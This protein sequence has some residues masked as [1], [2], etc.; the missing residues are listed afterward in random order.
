MNRT[1]VNTRRKP[2][3]TQARWERPAR[4]R[5]LPTISLEALEARTLLTVLDLTALNSSG[6]IN[7]AIFNQYTA[8]QDGT[9][10]PLSPFV[11]LLSSA[12]IVQ[13]YNT[14]A[15]PVQFNE[16]STASVTHGIQL[17]SVPS[18]IAP[19]GIRYYEFVL[20]IAQSDS[21]PLLSLDELRLYVTNP[22]TVQPASLSS[23]DS[24]TQTL[25]DASGK[26]YAPVYDLDAGG[27]S[28]V[29]LNADLSDKV[30]DG[31]G[32]GTPGDM[33][34][35]VPATDLGNDPSQYVYLY[36]K[37]GVNYRN[38]GSF[39]QWN[40]GTRP[41]EKT[42]SVSGQVYVDTNGD[43]LQQTGEPPLAGATV[44]LDA[45]NNGSFDT[46]ELTTVTGSDG[47]FSFSG[48][49]AGT[50]HVRAITPA[51]YV[52]TGSAS[53]DVTLTAGQQAT[54]TSFGFFAF[55]SLS[56]SRYRDLTGDGLSAD[57]PILNSQNPL[58]QPITVSLYKGAALAATTTIDAQGNYSF[59]NLGPGTYTVVEAVPS[60]WFQTQGPGAYTP[61]SGQQ[62]TGNN[63]DDFL[64][65]QIS[66]SGT[67]QVL[68]LH[69]TATPSSSLTVTQ[70]SSSGFMLSLDNKYTGT[71]TAPNVVNLQVNPA[72]GAS[73]DTTGVNA[74]PVVIGD[75]QGDNAYHTGRGGTT[76]YLNSGSSD[77]ISMAGG[78]NTLNLS[79]NTFGVT[80]DA[81]LTNGTPQPLDSTGLHMLSVS[82]QFQTVVGSSFNDK[83]TAA[84][85]MFDPT[86]GTVGAGTTII[87]G[88]G[89][90]TI[91]GSLGTKA[92]ILGSGSSY[93]QALS[94]TAL[95]TLAQAVQFGASA[96]VLS[97][98]G[99][100]VSAGGGFATI[101]AGILTN[102]NLSGNSNQFNQT[103]SSSTASLINQAVAQFG[104]TPAVLGGF[105]NT[106]TTLGRF[107]TVDASL[108][109]KVDLS[110]GSNTFNQV[111]DPGAVSVLQSA[112]SQFGGTAASVGG[113]GSA[114]G[115]LGSFRNTVITTGNSQVSASLLTNVTTEGASSTIVQGISSSAASVVDSAIQTMATQF[116]ATG[117]VAGGF[118]GVLNAL[119]AFSDT[120]N[121]IG[122]STKI[123]ATILPNV[124][125][126]GDHGVYV[127]GFDAGSASILAQALS[128]FGGTLQSAG[129]FGAGVSI[130]GGFGDT[131]NLRGSYSTIVSGLLTSVSATG[132][133]NQFAQLLDSNA[134]GVLNEAIGLFGGSAGVA[135][136]FGDGL[137]SL[138]GFGSSI[139]LTGN[140]SV[141]SSSL[142]SNVTLTGDNTTFV[143]GL[144]A[145]STSILGNAIAGF[146]SSAGVPGGFG[147]TVLATGGFGSSLS[148]PGGFGNSV[149]INGNYSQVGTSLL[150]NVNISGQNATYVEQLDSNSALLLNQALSSYGGAVGAIGGFG[151]TAAP[152]GGFGSGLNTLGGFGNTITINGNY[153]QVGTSLL[154]NVAVVGD[155][156]L[157]VEGIDNNALSVLSAAIS[158]F[159]GTTS[160]PGGFGQTVLATG[161]FG[162]SLGA[163][164]GFGNTLTLTGNFSQVVS[165]LVT[166]AT[167]SGQNSLY[168][169]RLDA[170]SAQALSQSIGSYGSAITAAGGFGNSAASAGGFGGAL[171]NLG[172]F[173]N[174]VLINGGYSQIGTSL[175]STVAVNSSA[176]PPTDQGHNLYIQALDSPSVNV[177]SAALAAFGNALGAPGGF[178]ASVGSGGGFGNSVSLDGGNNTINAGLL[179]SITATGGLNTFQQTIDT[180]AQTVLNA[181]LQT[182]QGFGASPA[183]LGGFSTSVSATGGFNNA[184]SGLLTKVVLSG[185]FDT[186]DQTLT[187][188]EAD[189]LKSALAQAA[190]VVPDA[191]AATAAA[192]GVQAQLTG[193]NDVFVG[194]LLITAT[195]PAGG[196]R[197]VLE[198]PTLLGTVSIDP[199]L[200]AYAT[201]VTN[202][203][204]PSTYYLVGTVLTPVI[205]NTPQ[206]TGD[207]LDLSNLQGSGIHL[208]LNQAGPQP[209][210]GANLVLTLGQPAAFATVIGNGASSSIRAGAAP[211]TVEG[212]APLDGRVNA[213]PLPPGSTQV[214]YLDFTTYA[215]PNKIDY[216]DPTL[217]AAIAAR[218]QSIF[219][220]FNVQIV[221]TP[222][223]AGQPYATVF[224]DETPTLN[225]VTAPGGLSSEID[226]RN[227]NL[228]DTSAVDITGFMGGAG[229]PPA[230]RADIIAMSATIASHEVEHTMGMRH[231]DAF[232]PIGF[233]IWN[234]PGP[235]AFRP[236]YPGAA[237]AWETHESLIA[238]PAS[239]GS[240]L[241]DAAGNP[242]IS[243]RE[244]VK[245]AFDQGG[246]VVSETAA[247]H[248][249]L[250]TAQ[251]LTLAPL[252][253]P[254]TLRSGFDAGKVL[255]VAA[256]DVINASLQDTTAGTL[257]SDFYS[258]SGQ[259]GDLMNLEVYSTSLTRITNSVD[260]EMYVY[261]PS[262]KLVSQYGGTA[263]NDDDFEAADP[264]LFDLK[265]PVNGTYTVEVR[266]YNPAAQPGNYELFMYRFQAGNAIPA[267][268]SADQFVMGPGNATFLGR[269][270][271]DTVVDSGTSTYTLANGSLTG[272]GT[273][274]LQNISQ[275]NLTGA[276]GGT[277]FDV[278]NW[279]GS[280]TL[281]GV[282]GTNTVVLNLGSRPG[283]FTLT[284]NTLTVS[285]GGSFTLVNIQNV[286]LTASNQGS[287]FNVNGWTGGGSLIG[288]P[289]TDS[290]Y[291]TQ[292]TDRMT[293][294]NQQ[295]VV[296]GA[297]TLQLQS[298]DSA[299][300]T[301]TL[302]GTTFDVRGWTAPITLDVA[303][304][305]NAVTNPHGLPVNS[306]EGSTAAVSTAALTD[307]GSPLASGYATTV[308]WGDNTTSSGIIATSGTTITGQ[309]TH[310]YEEGTFTVTTTIRQGLAFSVIVSSS[311][312][313]SDAAL[314]T[315]STAATVPM[316]VDV[317]GQ[318][319]V[320]FVDANPSAPVKDFSATI[321]WGD[322]TTPTT[323]TVTQSGAAGSPFTVSGS[324]VYTSTAN[325]TLKVTI[326][327]VG[328]SS[329]TATFTLLV[330]PSII[331]LNPT[332]SGA[333]TIKGTTNINVGGDVVIDSSSATA[334]SASG[335]STITAGK[336][337]VVGG[338]SISG[339]SVVTPAPITGAAAVPDPLASLPIPSVSGTATAVNLSKGSL[340]INPGVYTS[341]KVS[342]TGT[343]L[344][345]NPGVYVIKGG[346]FSVANASSV[347]GAG[348]VLYNA[349][350]NYPNAGGSFAAVS[351]GSSGTINLAAPKTG[352]YAG[353][354]IFQARDNPLGMSLNAGSAI[355]LNSI[356][357]APNA[358][359]S[360]SG[361][362]QLKVSAIVSQLLLSGNGGSTIT[363]SDAGDSTSQTAGQLLGSDL[364]VYVDSATPLNSDELARLQDALTGLA[365]LVAPYS[366]QVSLVTDPSLATVVVQQVTATS[367]GGQAAGILAQYDE[368]ATGG[369][370]EIVNG[371]NWYA[372]ADPL[373]VGAGQYDFETALL[374]ELGHALG[375][376]HRDDPASVMYATL[377]PGHAKRAL[378]TADLQIPELDTGAHALTATVIP[379]VQSGFLSPIAALPTTAIATLPQSSP[380]VFSIGL[381]TGPAGATLSVAVPNPA[382]SSA[383][384]RLGGS[385]GRGAPVPQN[386]ARRSLNLPSPGEG[387]LPN[388]LR[389]TP[390]IPLEFYIPDQPTASPL[391]DGAPS[392]PNAL[393]RIHQGPVSEQTRVPAQAEDVPATDGGA[394]PSI[395]PADDQAESTPAFA[396]LALLL[397]LPGASRYF[398]RLRERERETSQRGGRDRNTRPGR[399]RE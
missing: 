188:P 6:M 361:S 374:H 110:S 285:S 190:T 194:G 35:L 290:L 142:L 45:N 23:Y 80:F 241:F 244:A 375:L 292:A 85:A 30:N 376:G 297:G 329:V 72:A 218:M 371:W 20:S 128:S 170:N 286:I 137:N 359:L 221:L 378:T 224:F 202:G 252:S 262:G 111:L 265:L 271:N 315:S 379:M 158:S 239:V 342:G 362:A 43:G 162:G 138:G 258:F 263:F 230:T 255:S 237:A 353:L 198:D 338:A 8:P 167:I 260:T 387:D 333:L 210:L 148:S 347:T 352:T 11:R 373:G 64:A 305:P 168:F 250:G 219:A 240:S 95:S 146:G 231:Q 222:P 164:G 54:G 169:Q 134:A 123:S 200:L 253:V 121:A 388:R 370:V 336:V 112:I 88:G 143:Q 398:R 184:Q 320:T 52:A 277:T 279:T 175:L 281:T 90:D 296:D 99:S 289:G 213:P 302:G 368:N 189:F 195:A 233:G 351:L 133:N 355:G 391:R 171:N 47:K 395:T 135:G 235:A 269:G 7:G 140:F 384:F 115:A 46:G 236:Q 44:Y 149:S 180:N 89:Q 343:V 178:G 50:Y 306:V 21:S 126:T 199:S 37:F 291:V 10:V 116:G 98:F 247:P 246:T 207:T 33:T 206:S 124:N 276:P 311:A 70:N 287:R 49:A 25:A 217:Q 107:N 41:V 150:T 73:V 114:L 381:A 165:S 154:T 153:S 360:V 139:S 197:F 14:N 77:S 28:W 321:D 157:Y 349:G 254:N 32:E 18:L 280:A 27:D 238:S 335:G 261:D 205:V 192:L 63:L 275:A 294:N 273:A 160:V 172:G 389:P 109:S 328:G 191:R 322:G 204:A 256:V 187:Q 101:S 257:E 87:T 24:T 36:S 283:D 259:A 396:G 270:G 314:S 366:V 53:A 122:D 386:H 308:A 19:G 313:V 102:V 220:G 267:S 163:P 51:G 324:H 345:M 12:A 141:V 69:T 144:D 354:L 60:G 76:L 5:R 223:P 372:Q 119:G 108:L 215:S 67:N 319:I 93:T 166:N 229:E 365:Q 309:G 326:Q 82:G 17:G 71:F 212:A 176:S 145:T 81:S 211:V 227:L 330:A 358:L 39:Q 323:G 274:T 57:D 105:G 79:T 48:M 74:L 38:T 268:G 251:P 13:G 4:R 382:G 173:G 78:T 357:Y 42:G 29:K 196:A 9:A 316:G 346:G 91:V 393:D 385:N 100:S 151:S 304:D 339:G 226:F 242:F 16:D 152:A 317:T 310:A 341:I 62:S 282:G 367:L 288:G 177:L 394:L 136:G 295:L 68:Q 125:L 182:M 104:N 181:A 301:S 92:T 34:V 208:D 2:R 264:V 66:S 161:G 300:L 94:S 26:R 156:S 132:T 86:T 186:F 117:G 120:V 278:S 131:L 243:E 228:S 216:S 59:S 75:V 266:A 334:L 318:P 272:T 397:G 383:R 248:N 58:Y 232:G 179:T 303:G 55:A 312:T 56:G 147:G 84:P 392:S 350:S 337:L 129:G 103:I 201:S 369:V 377:T 185:G 284:G 298:I 97:G 174:H 364:S 130:P 293:I 118:G 390:E 331:V 203:L 193:L 40:L 325:P 299:N 127:Q 96:G 22:S 31:N 214:V 106:I 249:T 15:R 225:G 155:H 183:P 113:F 344:T 399:S 348:V 65:A 61:T 363:T 3:S 327:D 209:V 380:P 234:P 1:A 245:L 340:T 332:L 159:G 83:I 307:L 356:I